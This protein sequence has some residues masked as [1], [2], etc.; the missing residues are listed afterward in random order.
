[1]TAKVKTDRARYAYIFD[2]DGVLADSLDIIYTCFRSALEAEGVAFD[3]E[4]YQTCGGLS[5]MDIISHVC[6]EQ[7]KEESTEKIFIHYHKL[8]EESIRHTKPI[9]CNIDLLKNLQSCKVPVAIASGSPKKE[10]RDLLDLFDVQVEVVVSAEEV[11]QGKPEPDVFLRAA[12]LLQVNPESCVV[13]EDGD[14]GIRAAFKAGMRVL[15]YL[16]R[17]P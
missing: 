15:K 12:E 7:D 9:A 13:V 8:Y 6:R 10:V 14:H 2:F 17:L 4:F 16:D 1:V 11:K 5:P 3:Y